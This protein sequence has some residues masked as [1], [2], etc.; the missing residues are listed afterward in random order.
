MKR[1]LEHIC[2]LDLSRL[3]PGAYCTQLLADLG[4]RVLKIEQPGP[5]DYMRRLNPALFGALNRN[6]DSMT[7]NIKLPRGREIL[8]RL[9]KESNV[10]FESFRPGV[11]DRL[12]L[13]Y[14]AV[15]NANP[16]IVYCSLTGYGQAGPGRDRSGHDI[17]YLSVSGALS[18][19]VDPGERP[20]PPPMPLADLA[21]GLAASHAVLAGLLSQQQGGGGCYIDAALTDAA[22]SFMSPRLVPALHTAKARREDLVRGGA[23]DVYRTRDRRWVSLG[24]IEDKFW[25]NLLRALGREELGQDARFKTDQLRCQHRRDL[26]FILEPLMEQQ[27]LQVWMDLFNREDV[28]AAPVNR[29]DEV[30]QDPH[31]GFR[32]M[33]FQLEDHQG[34]GFKQV[35]YPASFPGIPSDRDRPAPAQGRDTRSVLGSL[36]FGE[37]DMHALE[38]EGVIGSGSL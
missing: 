24:V 32:G 17:N 12:G 16:E 31:V 20:M 19:N 23:Y 3:L 15:C 11:M 25:Q 21:G 6:K 36:G 22:L 14:D 9:I 2:V 28:P 18:L 33:V 38:K 5:G 26:R 1:L 37:E 34:R 4:A 29:L 30:E 7:L 27:D 10:F 35:A 13:G 8:L